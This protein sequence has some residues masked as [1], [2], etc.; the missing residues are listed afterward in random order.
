MVLATGKIRYG[1]SG[2]TGLR[3]KESDIVKYQS[4]HNK[5]DMTR[6]YDSCNETRNYDIDEL[7]GGL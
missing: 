6:Y 1:D 3:T 5:M 2:F 4:K 7:Y